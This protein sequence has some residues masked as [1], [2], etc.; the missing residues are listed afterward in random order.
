MDTHKTKDQKMDRHSHTGLSGAAKKGGGGGKGTWGKG[1]I[2]D[3]ERV[4]LATDDPNYDSEGEEAV[5]EVVL[6]S[7]EV[8]PP[9]EAILQEFFDEGAIEDTIKSIQEASSPIAIPEFVR[10]CMS[11]SMEKQPFERELV[12]KL[13]S[14]LYPKIVSLERM[15]E[16]FQQLLDVLDDVVLD[17]PSAADMTGKFLARAIIDEIV[18]PSFL[19]TAFAESPLAKEAVD[20][21]HGL[22]TDHHR[23][24]KLAHIWGPGDLESVKRLK[25]E[26]DLLIE[27]YLIGGDLKEA[28]N[29]VRKLNAPSFHSQLV[30]HAL[31]LA[32]QKGE[33]QKRKILNL[34]ASF[35]ASNK[36]SGLIT[37]DHMA[38]G[39]KA[40][41]DEIEDIKLDVPT[42]GKQLEEFTA[43]AKAEKWLI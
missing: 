35:S 39:F 20:M 26:V 38:Q 5:E 33:E 13:L 29:C 28:D 32:T 4:S 16:G 27:E 42:A 1:G 17:V 43:T 24:K 37:P 11:K 36:G 10:K 25:E 14:A 19:K 12:S 21:A 31:K 23:S 7:V 22:T 8:T 41:Q 18:P 34:L 6:K 40:F 9:I 3:L 30:K 2:D 15:V